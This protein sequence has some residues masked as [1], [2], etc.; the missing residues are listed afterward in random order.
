MKSYRKDEFTDWIK[1]LL[2][3]LFTLHT[4]PH[5]EE[6]I[7][8]LTTSQRIR[9]QYAEILKDVRELILNKIEFDK[10]KIDNDEEYFNES[11]RWH[12]KIKSFCSINW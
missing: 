11:P 5:D 10:K 3:T 6:D 1:W 12:I 2:A 8:N 7:D 4:V 9:F